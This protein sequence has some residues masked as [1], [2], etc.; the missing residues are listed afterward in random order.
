MVLVPVDKVVPDKAM[1]FSL[2]KVVRLSSDTRVY[3]D[4]HTFWLSSQID[5]NTLFGIW[6]TIREHFI[7]STAK[8]L[9]TVIRTSEEYDSVLSIFVF[10]I[11]YH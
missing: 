7:F 6:N 11:D 2:D 8:D 5:W 3:K 10:Q 4:L 9:L 1:V